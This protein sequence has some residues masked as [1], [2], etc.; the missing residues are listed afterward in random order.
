[1]NKRRLLCRR[2]KPDRL[3]E[4]LAV[5]DKMRRVFRLVFACLAVLGLELLALRVSGWL[6]PCFGDS[7]DNLKLGGL[8][9]YVPCIVMLVVFP[10]TLASACRGG[11]GRAVHR[12]AY[13]V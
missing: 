13:P 7:L 9:F 11:P 10:L 5:G 2:R 12:S 6:W 8:L 1:M 3:I 4:E